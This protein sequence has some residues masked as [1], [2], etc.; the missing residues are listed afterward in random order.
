[1]IKLH[2]AELTNDGDIPVINFKSIKEL[3]WYLENEFCGINHSKRVYLFCEHE[4]II[5]NRDN[6]SKNRIFFIIF[7]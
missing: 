3:E 4:T 1:M 2:Y 7:K 6:R 5:N